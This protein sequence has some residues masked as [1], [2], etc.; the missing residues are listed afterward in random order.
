MKRLA[1]ILLNALTVLSLV[2]FLATV[3]LW[4]RSH[5]MA[6]TCEFTNRGRRWEVTVTRGKLWL[7]NSPQR[8]REAETVAAETQRIWLEMGRVNAEREAA[9]W[10]LGLARR[11]GDH[12]RAGDCERKVSELNSQWN[13]LWRESDRRQKLTPTPAVRD[14]VVQLVVPA[15]ALAVPPMGWLFRCVRARKRLHEFQCIMCGYDLR[16]TPERCPEC[17]TILAR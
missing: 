3:T 2:L 14:S 7:D 12:L 15:L 5:F 16:A 10:D 4:V 8:K 1:R 9:N 6:V 17:G 13:R 11:D